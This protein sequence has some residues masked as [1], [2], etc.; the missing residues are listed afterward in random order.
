MFTVNCKI[1]QSL[2]HNCSILPV[3]TCVYRNYLCANSL[4][5]LDRLCISKN[6]IRDIV[7]EQPVAVE[8]FPAHR[9]HYSHFILFC[10]RVSYHKLF[11]CNGFGVISLTAH[12][13]FWHLARCLLVL[14]IKYTTTTI[15]LNSIYKN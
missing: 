12:W 8:Y 5:I 6:S 10:S 13:V 9:I 15:T 7:L 14:E 2:V 3:F 11:D 4:M 1:I